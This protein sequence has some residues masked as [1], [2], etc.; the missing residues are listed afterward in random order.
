MPLQSRHPLRLLA[1]IGPILLAGCPGF[2]LPQEVI[3]DNRDPGVLVIAGQWDVADT[4]D[5]NGAYG[6]DFMFHPADRANVARVRFTPDVVVA[7]SYGVYIWW[8]AAPNRTTEQ[9]VI[10]HDATGDVTYHVNLQQHGD[11]WFLLGYHTFYSGTGGFVE[12]S[13]DTDDSG[14]CI[15]DAIRLAP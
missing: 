5:G 6:Q 12:F 7:G 2:L 13:T 9:P 1:F 14:F 8:S 10:V 4:S 11:Q 3:V 15:A